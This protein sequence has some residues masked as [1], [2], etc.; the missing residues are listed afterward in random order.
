LV[1][2]GETT[3]GELLETAI[4]RL[5]AVNPVINAVTVKMY[6]AAQ[7][8]IEAGLPDGPLSGVPFL[9]KDLFTPYDGSPMT[10]G[11]RLYADYVC[12]HDSELVARYRRAGLVVFGRTNSPEMGIAYTTEPHLHGPTRNPWDLDRTPGGSSGGAAAAIAA[13]IVPAAHASDGG[14]SIR[15]PASC[16]G[17]FGLKPT[18][19]RTP[20]GPDS[21]EGWAGMSIGH[22]I[23][24][25]V[26]DSAALLDASAGPDVGDPYWA[27]PAARP[28]A[29]EAGADPGQLRIAVSADTPTGAPV[30]A[31]CIAAMERAAALC[32]DLGH[33]VV[34]AAPVYDKEALGDAF[35]KI[36]TAN[37]LNGVIESGRERGRDWAGEVENITRAMA[38]MGAHVSGAEYTAAVNV[39]HRVGRQVARFMLDYDVLLTP[40]MAKPPLL[41]GV[42]DMMSDDVDAYIAESGAF[43]AFPPLSNA[44]GAPAMSVP[45][46]WTQTG[47]PVGA[48][49]VG[50]FGDEA[51]L[52]RLAGQLEK[53]APWVQRR[54]PLEV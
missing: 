2:E 24:L 39:I 16:C 15:V 34:E 22:A 36:I 29:D 42:L 30:D 51:T 18:R 53:A 1:R 23:T 45:L 11:S 35:L 10:N 19:G 4:A 20:S 43:A 26:R 46:Y 13:R 50:R 47:L 3:A 48:Q 7:T 6:D 54:P 9:L 44:T 5:E 41:L 28:F 25:S 27:P 52:L 40:T 37:T 14:G 8:A 12:D 31:E 33:Q 38:E 17:L 49:F 21:G 32:A